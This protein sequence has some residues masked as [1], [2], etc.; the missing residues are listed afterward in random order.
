MFAHIIYISIVFKNSNVIFLKLVFFVSLVFCVCVGWLF[1]V[2]GIGLFYDPHA[3]SFSFAKEKMETKT[4]Q[5]KRTVYIVLYYTAE[6]KG[7]MVSGTQVNGFY[8]IRYIV[9]STRVVLPLW[10]LIF[11]SYFLFVMSTHL[12][13]LVVMPIRAPSPSVWCI[14]TRAFAAYQ[15]SITA[16]VTPQQTNSGRPP[17]SPI[18]AHWLFWE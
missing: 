13:Y 17:H 3:F 4:K 6:K 14:T 5:E 11:S 15:R 1:E 2:R 16:P 10:V 8:I 9:H 7:L 18:R 12:I